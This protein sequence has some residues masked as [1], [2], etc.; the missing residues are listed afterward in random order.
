MKFNIFCYHIP[1]IKVMVINGPPF[2][3]KRRHPCRVMLL[4]LIS[5]MIHH[6]LDLRQ[7]HLVCL[8]HGRVEVRLHSQLTSFILFNSM[9]DVD[10]V[11]GLRELFQCPP[12][13][14]YVVNGYAQLWAQIKTDII[15][16]SMSSTV[17]IVWQIWCKIAL[18]PYPGS[19][20]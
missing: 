7:H 4:Y 5:H 1:L 9:L 19:N 10:K 16:N 11:Q 2:H 12:H 20:H 3:T 15:N 17:I 18:S 6:S 13:L 8:F 14:F